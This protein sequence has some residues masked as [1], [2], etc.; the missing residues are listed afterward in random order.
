[1]FLC[2]S[3]AKA[4]DKDKDVVEVVRPV[5]NWVAQLLARHPRPEED[6]WEEKPKRR[7]KTKSEG[8][9]KPPVNCGDKL[10]WVAGWAAKEMETLEIFPQ[11]GRWSGTAGHYRVGLCWVPY[12]EDAR[13]E[14]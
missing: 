12:H 5:P 9:T 3:D 6:L 13:E 2:S 8:P 10:F 7:H 4:K 14:L 1:M 11:G